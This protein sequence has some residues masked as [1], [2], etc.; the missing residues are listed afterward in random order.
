MELSNV[1]LKNLQTR[2][3][4]STLLRITTSYDYHTRILS[5]DIFG[6]L[7]T[8][9]H[10]YPPWCP[11]GPTSSACMV[12]H[13]DMLLLSTPTHETVCAKPRPR[14]RREGACS[15]HLTL[16]RATYPTRSHIAQV[17]PKTPALHPRLTPAGL[18]SYQRHFQLRAVWELSSPS[19]TRALPHHQIHHLCLLEHKSAVAL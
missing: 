9:H 1:T 18:R 2:S 3:S 4:S 14:P 5:F 13:Q 10:T 17:A 16:L 6:L 12:N 11:L 15:R 7:I 19:L 8:P